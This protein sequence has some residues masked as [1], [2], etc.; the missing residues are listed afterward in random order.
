MRRRKCCSSRIFCYKRRRQNKTPRDPGG[1]RGPSGITNERSD[2]RLRCADHELFSLFS[3]PIHDFPKP[4]TPHEYFIFSLIIRP[5]P[6]CLYIYSP[7]YF[8]FRAL[9]TLVSYEGFTLS[10]HSRSSITFCYICALNTYWALIIGYLTRSS[11]P[12]DHA[13]ATP[14]FC[15]LSRSPT[16]CDLLDSNGPTFSRGIFSEQGSTI[17]HSWP[18]VHGCSP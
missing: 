7:L 10:S 3:D 1:P 2:T 15:I 13:N 5:L 18:P 9:P 12:N 16:A 11:I 14:L 4:L 8:D 17:K 6:L